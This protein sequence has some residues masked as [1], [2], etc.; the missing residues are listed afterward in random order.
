MGLQFT[1]TIRGAARLAMTASCL[2]LPN[3]LNAA[4]GDETYTHPGELVASNGTRLNLYCMGS[5]SPAVVF[6]SGWED[7]APVWAIVQPRVAQWT[8]A[9]SYDRAGTGFSDPGSMPR[10]SVQ[11]ADEL[12]GALHNAG[13]KGPYILVG[14][15]FGGDNVRTFAV[16]YMQDV[17]GMVLVEADVGGPNEHTGDAGRIAE[18][19]EC[20]NAVAAGKPLPPLPAL[21]D[22]PER[23]CAQ[24]FFR[25]LPEPAWSPQL[26]ASLLGLAQTKV[27]MYDADISEMEQMR[28]DEIYLEQNSRSFGSRPIRVLSTGYHGIHEIDPNHPKSAEQQKYE[29]EVARAQARWLALSSDAKQL[30]ISNSSEYIPFDQPEFVVDAI[31]QV[32]VA[33]SGAGSMPAPRPKLLDLRTP[34]GI[35]LKAS[36]FAA[37]QPGPGVVLFH[38][39]NR[40]RQSWDELATRMADAGIN[41]LTVDDRGHGESGGEYDKAND[42]SREHAAQVWPADLDAAFEALLAQPGVEADRIGV[43]GAGALGVDNAVETARRHSAAV[44]TLVLISG[45]TLRPQLQFLHQATHLPGLYVVADADEYPPTVEAMEWLYATSTSPQK[46]LVHY[47]GPKAPWLWYEPFDIGRVPAA[48]GH[49]TDL[50]KVHPELPGVILDWWVTT[51]IRTPGHAPADAVAAAVVLNQIATPGGVAQV[52]EM[53]RQARRQD[54]AF[55]LFPEINVSII[56]NDYL[57]AGDSKAAIEVFKLNL[58]AYPDSADAHADLADAYLQDGH[59]ELAQQYA[60]KALALLSSHAAPAS[61]WSDTEPRRA[62]IRRDAE[63]ALKRSGAGSP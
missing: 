57:R 46:Q 31:H 10:T 61:S 43:G 44:K 50:F 45:E 16:R 52:T 13:I 63:R 32:Y 21:P 19:R 7:W 40:T 47:V 51:L 36:Y 62:E 1:H 37:A 22:S 24:Q 54:P 14:H 9:C 4:P 30:F 17:A 39:S 15:A 48:G 49:G 3:L 6:D 20:R 29:D 11:I 38:Q 58:L 8:R 18:L 26:N 56:G 33:N 60:Q 23:S 55:Q 28:N 2:L 42:P 25:G 27:A 53:L 41:T 35:V 34:D 59:R 5:G 12:H